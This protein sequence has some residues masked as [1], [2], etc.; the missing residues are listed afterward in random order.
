MFKWFKKISR[1]R[2]EEISVG[3]R[4]F[5]HMKGIVSTSE[6]FSIVF[7]KARESFPANQGH[8]YQ[9]EGTFSC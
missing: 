8:F 5:S 3:G 7:Q 4:L 2:V 1:L 9:K 6:G